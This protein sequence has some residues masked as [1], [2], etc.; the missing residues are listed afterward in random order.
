MSKPVSIC[1]IGSGYVGLVAAVCFSEIGHQVIF[2]DKEQ[3][4]V[5]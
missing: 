2:V 3:A 1:V 5:K 4:N